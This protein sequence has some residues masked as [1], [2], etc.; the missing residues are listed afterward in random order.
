MTNEA[1][2]CGV[3][4]TEMQL[5][6]RPGAN[7]LDLGVQALKLALADAG[8]ERDQVDGL[9][10]MSFGADYDRFLEASGMEVRYVYQGWSHGRFI[11]PTVQHA[12]RVIEAGLADY[13]AIVHGRLPLRIGTP[14]D[15]EMWRQGLGPHGESPAYGA[16]SRAYGTAIAAQRYFHKY[17]GSN[18]DLAPI[19][20]AFRKHASMNPGA[21]RRQPITIE[22]HQA[23]RWIVEPLRL[24]DC[25]QQNDGGACLIL[26]T[27]ARARDL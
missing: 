18:E 14:S 1:V 22:D 3:G 17:G 7:A 20:V 5:G 6:H 27:P 12:A 23:S 13:V 16:V 19:A 8:L 2:I 21:V 10:I 15:R 4:I 25:C 26:P 9:I 11:C 24:F